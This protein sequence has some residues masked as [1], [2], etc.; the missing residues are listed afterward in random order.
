[1]VL[2]QNILDAGGFED[3][4]DLLACDG[5]ADLVPEAPE[6]GGQGMAQD[7]TICHQLIQIRG[8][9]FTTKGLNIGIPHIICHDYKDIGFLSCYL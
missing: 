3:R 1:M 2:G 4:A 9:N 7:P 5:M 6:F 8:I